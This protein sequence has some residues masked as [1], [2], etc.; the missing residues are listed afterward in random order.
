[1]IPNNATADVTSD[2]YHHY[3]MEPKKGVDYYD[4]LIDYMLLQGIT[5]YANLYHYDLPLAIENEYLGWLSPKI[6]D[7]FADYAD[8]CFKRFGDRVKN[9]F[10]MNEPRVIADCGYSSGYHAP[11]RCTGCKFGG[12][13]STK[14]Y[15]LAHNLILSHAVAVERYREKYQI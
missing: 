1:M 15:T 10:T 2:E 5:P 11:G 6:V 3:K 7:A 14:P 8:F 12:N 4:R 9:W 13:S